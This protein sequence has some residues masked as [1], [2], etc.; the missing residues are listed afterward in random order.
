MGGSEMDKQELL[1]FNKVALV[2]ATDREEKYGNVILKFLK[3]YTSYELYP[4]NPNLDSA[5]LLGL[6]VYPTLRDIPEKIDLVVTVVPPKVTD[7]I[8]AEAMALGI[9][10]F[11]CQPGAATPQIEDMAKGRINLVRDECIMVALG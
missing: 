7:Q 4:V 6:Q 1:R 2:G 8:L 5:E 10:N 3:R 11:W 9:P